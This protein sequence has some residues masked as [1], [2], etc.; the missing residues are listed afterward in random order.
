MALEKEYHRANREHN[1]TQRLMLLEFVSFEFVWDLL[2]VI[3]YKDAYR[4]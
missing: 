3:F 4:K 2:F 1:G